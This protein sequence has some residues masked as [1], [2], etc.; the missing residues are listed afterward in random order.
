MVMVKNSPHADHMRIDKPLS[1]GNNSKLDLWYTPSVNTQ[2]IHHYYCG[3]S[4]VY[5]DLSLHSP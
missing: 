3:K 1:C 2:S 5:L 4:R